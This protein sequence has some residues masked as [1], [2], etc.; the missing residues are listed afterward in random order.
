[1]QRM[2]FE[3]PTDHYDEHLSSIDEKICSLLKE[4]KELSNGNPGFPPDEAISNWAKQNG[5][6]PDYLN[7]LFSSMMD[8]DEFKPRVEPTKFKKHIPVLKTYE[9]KEDVYT[10]TFIRQYSNA[11]V[12]Y[13]YKE[14]DSKNKTLNEKNTHSLVELSI[15]D[16]YDCSAEGWTGTDG[17]VSYQFVVS[18][19]LPDNLS[20]ISLRFKE[21]SM[22]FMKDQ[23]MLEF[24][25]Q[26][27]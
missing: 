12:I 11:S 8:E 2:P 15:S 27:D 13:L 23:A 5:L 4:R 16:T 26:L 10:V 20:G 9:H 24:E 17:H 21:Q 22:P 19:T 7:S 18:P 6:Y 3:R 25:I 1:M 14:W